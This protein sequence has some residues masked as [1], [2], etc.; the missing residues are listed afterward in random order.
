MQPSVGAGRFGGNIMTQ[1]NDA[2]IQSSSTLE[3]LL[4]LVGDLWQEDL[5][6]S[7]T[8]AVIAG[9][10]SAQSQ[11]NGWNS[12][13]RPQLLSHPMVTRVSDT[14]LSIA[15]PSTVDYDISATET[16]SAVV[17]PEALQ[18]GQAA[19]FTRP[20]LV[21]PARPRAHVYSSTGM[22]IPEF[23]LQTAEPVTLQ[24]EL[25][26]AIFAAELGVR[27][28]SIGVMTTLSFL[29]GLVSTQHTEPAGWA[30]MVAPHFT[31]SDLVVLSPNQCN[32]SI[33]QAGGYRLNSPESIQLTIPALSLQYGLAPII[34][35]PPLVVE[36]SDAYAELSGT[37]FT[38][39]NEDAL[40][41]PQGDP[42]T[43]RITLF[44]TEWGPYTQQEDFGS[45]PTSD[46]L[47]GIKSAQ[48]EPNGWNNVIAPMLTAPD[49]T[50]SADGATIIITL[51]PAP[52][53]Q[54]EEPETITVTIPGG[55]PSRSQAL[56]TMLHEKPLVARPVF[57]IDP[58][59]GMAQLS[60]DVL[61][62]NVDERWLSLGQPIYFSI[63]LT[64][65]EFV[66]DVG[67]E[68]F[69]L[70][71]T[72]AFLQGIR[73]LQNSITGFNA[74]LQPKLTHQNINRVSD[75]ELTV[76]ISEFFD[77]DISEAETIQVTIP[78]AA[79]KSA[80]TIVASPAFNIMPTFAKVSVSGELASSSSEMA[81][82]AGLKPRLRIM[83][84]SDTWVR[85]VGRDAR[86]DGP[87]RLLLNGLVS[88]QSEPNG[89]NAVIGPFLPASSLT[90]I[91]PGTVE[92]VVPQ[93]AAYDITE[94]ETI[95]VSIPHVAMRNNDVD[96]VGA[97]TFVIMA[98]PGSA[99]IAGSIL[100]DI[101]E[102]A[103]VSG[104]V[105]SAE[106]VT[107]DVLLD[108]D[109]FNDAPMCENGLVNITELRSDPL[110]GEWC[111]PILCLVQASSLRRRRRHQALDANHI[112]KVVS[113]T[114]CH[115][116]LVMRWRS[117]PPTTCVCSC[118]HMLDL[119]SR[120]SRL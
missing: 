118:P 24:V 1:G 85:T 48:S 78:A 46:L 7:A 114:W 25:S 65:D 72:T 94:P 86:V 60:G 42:L 84:E 64:G 53:Y 107:I 13:I 101:S 19:V 62:G 63:T 45:G 56:W 27:T 100:A 54:I 102:T 110:P 92:M 83:L 20:F 6:E 39:G 75:S 89:W 29:N 36:P 111:W 91:D 9:I 96:I 68:D 52:N 90:Y 18:S 103:L 38:S 16:I 2:S 70:G 79:L 41:S 10:N 22:L 112:R 66:Q 26:G 34:A 97:A 14:V 17:P 43:I 35:A 69:G 117:S 50:K 3:L 12:I 55:D 109:T 116:S 31:I 108:D 37:L 106:N 61:S 74:I 30:T 59:L 23:T 5:T 98:S 80:M 49:V 115:P 57:R 77:Y 32:I 119:T 33:Q 28:S 21:Y 87:T 67:Q 82:S 95:T 73:S 15:I 81:I 58:S 105:G 71:A 76:T 44:G 8:L 99:N 4:T 104:M 51:P 93:F 88:Q 120:R 11:A 113:T 40:R 47:R